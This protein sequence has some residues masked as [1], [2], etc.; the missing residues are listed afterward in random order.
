MGTREMRGE[1]QNLASGQETRGHGSGVRPKQ[2]IQSQGIIQRPP[3]AASV[4]PVKTIIS[5]VL[6]LALT[7]F[8]LFTNQKIYTHSEYAGALEQ[9]GVIA[10]HFGPRDVLLLRGGAPSFS[11]DIPDNLATPLTYA[12]GL[13]AFTVKSEQPGKYAQQLARYVDQWRTEGREVYLLL[14]A[15]GA[16][17]LPGYAL[18]PQG[19]ARLALREFEQPTTQKPS[20]IQNFTL[21]FQMY[22]LVPEAERPVL[23]QIAVDDYA[24]QVTGFYRAELDAGSGQSIAWTNG[25]AI[26]RIPRP[27]GDTPA[28]FVVQLAA[29]QSR[30]A[31]LL[32]VRVCIDYRAE[33]QP[34]ADD[35]N[36]PAFSTAECF[37]LG[38][39]AQSY[40]LRI[41]PRSYI[42][43]PGKTVLIRIQSDTW[44][45]ARDDPQQHD[46]RVLGVQLLGAEIEVKR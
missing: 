25:S 22:K 32:P 33:L 36:A 26:L 8:N 18:Q 45:P 44:I 12:F 24:R 14:S 34:W 11:R 9:L 39:D 35:P 30:P 37:M 7:L 17:E 19:S 6:L 20:N 29:G 28:D 15:S 21:D 43:I 27:A 1:T 4:L 42:G 31:A 10:R 23:S 40:T 16:L 46:R 5:L 2:H 38:N 13:N 3:G 41:D